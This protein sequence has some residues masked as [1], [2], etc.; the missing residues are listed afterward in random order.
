MNK[1]PAIVSAVLFFIVM[2]VE[3]FQIPG[4]FIPNEQSIS[5][6]GILLMN[7]YIIPFE[8]LSLILVAGILGMMHISEDD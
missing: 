1:I 6:I 3:V 7:E 5:Q 4:S 8:L 2:A